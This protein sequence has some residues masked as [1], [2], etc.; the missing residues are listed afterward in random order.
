MSELDWTGAG[1]RSMRFDDVYFQLEDGLAESRAVYLQGCGLPE[2]FA[3]RE[4]FCVGELGFG[5]GLNMLALLDLWR[6]HR[7]SPTARLHMVSV[8]AYPITPAEAARALGAFPEL[9]ELAA[10]L[11]MDWPEGRIG[12]HVIAFPAL[13]AT[14]DLLIGEVEPVLAGLDA[15]MDAWFLDGFAP[16]KNPQMWTEAVLAEVARCTAPGGIAASFTVAGDVRRRLAE[17]GFVVE[18]RPGFG[19]KRQKLE[20][21]M[22]GE[23]ADP[24]RPS[25]AVIGAGICGG[26]LIRALR[27]EGLSPELFEAVGPAFGASGNPAGLVNPRLDAGLG[28]QAQLHA[29]CF[30]RV[31]QLIRTTAPHCLIA[32]GAL[33]LAATPKDPDRFRKLDGWNGFAPGGLTLLSPDE[34]E[35]RMGEPNATPSLRLRDALTIEPPELVKAFLGD[36]SIHTARVAKV[37]SED[38]KWRLIDAHGQSLGT[39]DRVC[40][41]TGSGTMGL[42]EGTKLRPVRGQ[43]TISKQRFSGEAASWGGYVIPTR[44]GLLFGATHQRDDADAAPRKADDEDNLVSLSKARPVL[45]EQVRQKPVSHRAAV[46]VFVPDHLPLCGALEPGLYILSAMGGR[47]L[48]LAPLLGEEIAATIAGSP[49]PL[50]RSLAALVDPNRPNAREA[51]TAP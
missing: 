10:D 12:P 25:V 3:G 34:A 43:V 23:S 24:P 49:R 37:S 32:R 48:S 31:I 20:A 15:K 41:A 51:R 45:A 30:T 17:G 13:N 7:P 28:S 33:Q 2:R 8:E 26:A 1:P 22:P 18:R 16:A 4:Q 14:L 47:G 6:R 50:A 29:Q 38:G 46:R 21:V 27:D 42:I 40:V 9:A 36:V 11:L 44:N 19:K 39:F 5:T 35:R